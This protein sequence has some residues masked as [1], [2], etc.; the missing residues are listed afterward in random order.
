MPSKR[1][2]RVLFFGS[3]K[4]SREDRAALHRLI[5]ARIEALPDG[6]VVI[7]GGAPIVDTIAGNLAMERGLH[8]AE[9]R[10][11]WRLAKGRGYAGPERNRVMI[12]VLQ[13]DYA[14]G[15]YAVLHPLAT[16][17]TYD[18]A[19]RLAT[20]GVPHRLTWIDG[21]VELNEVLHESTPPFESGGFSS[22]LEEAVDPTPGPPA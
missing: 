2:P 6:A 8:A 10:A 3:H 11:L 19:R 18:C 12:E 1:P 7:H 15:F 5:A 13:P 22:A 14:E 20:A 17:G 16:P 9:V 21:R 4:A